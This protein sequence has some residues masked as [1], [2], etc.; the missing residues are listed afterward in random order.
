MGRE[1]LRGVVGVV[2]GAFEFLG[3]E[4]EARELADFAGDLA[5]GA[6]AGDDFL[7]FFGVD[8]FVGEFLERGDKVV[9]HGRRV[10]S[11]AWRKVR[12]RWKAGGG[13]GQEPGR[14]RGGWRG[15]VEDDVDVR[16]VKRD[17]D[18]AACRGKVFDVP[19]DGGH[20]GALE[21]VVL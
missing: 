6:G 15:G 19:A 2:G 3:V 14:L 18:A 11:W 17:D 4:G 13:S 5:L 12:I 21:R 9:V 10:R 1:R 7:E 16:V 8:V 20:D